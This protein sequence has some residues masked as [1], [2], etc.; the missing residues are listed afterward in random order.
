MALPMNATRKA[1]EETQ[2][3]HVIKSLKENIKAFLEN[4]RYANQ[5]VD[6]IFTF[7]TSCL[8]YLSGMPYSWSTEEGHLVLTHL[9]SLVLDLVQSNDPDVLMACLKSI[10]KIFTQAIS[11][12]EM[13]LEKP[14][15]DQSPEDLSKLERYKV[16]LQ[17]KYSN[18]KERLLELLDHSNP[19]IQELSLCSLMKFV[20]A[21]GHTPLKEIPENHTTFPS[22]LFEPLI[23]HLLSSTTNLSSLMSRFQE[24]LE[25]DDVR[26]FTMKFIIQDIKGRT[27]ND[28]TETYLTNVHAMLENLSMPLIKPDQ[29]MELKTFISKLPAITNSVKS[30]SYKEHKKLFTT[31]WLDF[32]KLKLPTRLYKKVL[33]MMHD[34]V[35][36]YMTSPLL[37]SDFLTDSYNIGGA[38]S[39]LALNGLFILV[40]SYNLNYPDFYEKLY[41]LFEPSIFHVKYKARFFYLADLFLTSTHLPAYL[42][43][44][45]AKKLAR[46]SLCAP[47]HCLTIILPFLHNLLTRH[48]SC[49]VLINRTDVSEF[50]SD[51]FLMDER[52]LSKCKA[53]ES[54]LWEIK[55]LQS[56]FHHTITMEANKFSHKLNQREIDLGPLLETTIGDLLEK[57]VKRKVKDVP[58]TFD[59]TPSLF[60]EDNDLVSELWS[61]C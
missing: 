42:V 8:A 29:S 18:V 57:E 4:K 13:F 46:L 60:T 15:R 30:A 56:H 41:A 37:L 3:K 28:Q 44:A 39:L 45:F 32:L 31:L 51:P 27:K 19:N 48:P 26:Y 14:L 43:A 35:I 47:P 7:Q 25:Y 55:S 17:E 59:V 9:L 6:I 54:S 53:L 23:T 38:I 21:E 5:L 40:N 33:L 34:K 2:S 24:Y 49:Q 11:N 50:E 58:L 16:W 36:P 61:W 10:P 52:D 22:Q 12:Q 1:E 20:E